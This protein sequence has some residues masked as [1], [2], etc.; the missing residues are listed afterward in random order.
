M[1][2]A[3]HELREAH[4][5]LEGSKHAYGGHKQAALKDIHLA[6]E[7]IEKAL[8]EHGGHHI[9]KNFG[10]D[11][12][13]KRHAHHPHLHEALHELREAHKELKEAKH[14]FGGHREA[15]IKA[16]KAAEK[17]IEVILKHAK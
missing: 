14:D 1:L 2:H 5:E 13:Y 15:A 6:I 8:K 9:P 12:D 17:Q 16:V 10:H 3:L 4:K 11:V 7:Q